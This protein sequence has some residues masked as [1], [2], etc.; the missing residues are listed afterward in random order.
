MAVNEFLNTYLQF[1]EEDLAEINIVDTATAKTD[2]EIIYVTFSDHD[3]IKDIYRRAAEIRNDHIQTRIFV[4]PQFW[5]RYQHI[6]QH[7]ANLRDEN[8]DIK[9]LIRFGN[10]DIEVMVKDRSNDDHYS[11]L[12]L[13]EIEKKG[14]ILKFKHEVVWKKRSEKPQRNEL[15]PAKGKIT[16]PSIQRTTL[17][18]TSSSGSD[19]HPPKRQKKNDTEVLET[20]NNIT[21]IETEEIL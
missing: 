13:E 19:L 4:L 6:A 1:N 15:K 8:K 3:T 16:P 2:E 14:S 5:P 10:D 21:D 9:T 17:S 7:C 12:S 11:T 20:S 18:R